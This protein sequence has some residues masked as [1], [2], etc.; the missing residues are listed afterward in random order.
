[1]GKVHGQDQADATAAANAVNIAVLQRQVTDLGDLPAQGDAMRERMVR[2]ESKTDEHTKQLEDIAY[3]EKW[4]VL[5]VFG[6]IGSM[7]LKTYRNRAANASDDERVL[8]RKIASI[9]S[10]E[11]EL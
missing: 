4:L 9:I 8:A 1:M 6:M 2:V 7:A 5:G 11:R 10:R 3:L